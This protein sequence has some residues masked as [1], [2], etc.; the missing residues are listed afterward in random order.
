MRRRLFI[1]LGGLGLALLAGA[2]A[3]HAQVDVKAIL[4]DPDAPMA[5]DPKGDVTIVA[6][7]DY[8]CPFCKK[9]SPELEKL[10]RGDG[11]IRL[12]YKDWPILSQASVHGAKLALAARYQGKYGAA[13]AALMGLTGKGRTE[14][15]MTAAVAAA[16]IDMARLQADL[17]AHDA[18]ISAL[19]QRNRAQAE[20]LGLEGTP[21]FLIGPYKIA[22]ALDRDGFAKVVA[23]VRAGARR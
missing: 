13:H 5:G 16:G 21:V 3:L 6:F 9:A 4:D 17:D 7:L 1:R 22:Q 11:H 2:S 15:D 19:L 10:A 8:N 12:I 14:D 20:A 18:E 23:R